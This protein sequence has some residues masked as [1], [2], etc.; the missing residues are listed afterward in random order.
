MI[1]HDNKGR[2]APNPQAVLVGG[3]WLNGA[4]AKPL[5]D[6]AYTLNQTAPGLWAMLKGEGRMSQGY[7]PA[8]WG[9]QAVK[10]SGDTHDEGY[11]LDILTGPHNTHPELSDAAVRAL[12]HALT[13]HG[14]AAPFRI[15][16]YDL[17]TVINHTEHV[18]A[19][20]A[21]HANYTACHASTQ[22]GGR[23]YIETMVRGRHRG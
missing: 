7:S 13:F 21:G 12:C 10:A 17:G 4:L 18:H 15:V 8:A 3:V 9:G 14:F 1:L 20:Y 22:P 11:S 23:A 5:N 6:V 2:K 16:G 19:V